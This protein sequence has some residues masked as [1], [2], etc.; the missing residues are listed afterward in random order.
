M[1]IF[2]KKKNIRSQSLSRKESI[3]KQIQSVYFPLA[4]LIIL[5]ITLLVAHKNYTISQAFA[6]Y[7]SNWDYKKVVTITNNSG[8]TLTDYHFL[9]TVNTPGKIIDGKI[10]SDCSDIR[11]VDSDDSTELD[12]W[13][14]TECD[15]ANTEIWIEI[16]S[17]PE[18]DTE[19][20]FYYGNTSA[21]STAL[22]YSGKLFT[23]ADTTCA[24]GYTY[25]PAFLGRFI[26]GGS[27]YGSL[28]G[29]ETHGHADT[30]CTT[31]GFTGSSLNVS[32]GL[33]G[34]AVISS[35]THNLTASV[36]SVSNSPSYRDALVCSTTKFEVETGVI[37]MSEKATLTGWTRFTPFDSRYPRA[38]SVYGTTGGADT[39]THS[40][41]PT[42]TSTSSSGTFA[43]SSVNFGDGADGAVTFSANTNI[44]TT[45]RIS[46]RTCSQGGD[47]VNYSVT[48]L[49]AGS[50]VVTPAPNT[51][52]L[53]AGDEILLINLQGVPSAYVNTGNY[54]VLEI[55]S[56]SGSTVNFVSSK[57]K[58]YGTGAANDLNLGT[59]TTNQRV[60]LQRIPN[61]T[62]VTVNGGVNV[63]PSAWNG[64]RGG[65][66]AFN[67]NGTTVINGTV[68][69]NGFGYRLG[70]AGAPGGKSDG[71][72]SFCSEDG[73][74]D[75]PAYPENRVGYNGNCGGGGGAG[76][77]NTIT[78][79]GGVGTASLGG[80]G[81]AGGAADF[82]WSAAGGGGAGGGYGTAG[83]QG[84]G[85]G[86]NPYYEGYPGGVNSSGNGG[87]AV[88]IAGP[89]TNYGGGGG[90]GGSYGDVALNKLYFG[91]GGGGG[92]SGEYNGNGNNTWGGPGGAGGGIV[93]ISSNS[94]T[95]GGATSSSGTNG[96]CGGSNGGCGGGGAGG[97]VKIVGDT[98]AIG[99]SKVTANGGASSYAAGSGRIALKYSTSWSGSSVPT[100]NVSQTALAGTTIG[101]H[102]HT[103][104]SGANTTATSNEIPYI[105]TV[106]HKSNGQQAFDTSTVVMTDTVPPLGWTEKVNYRNNFAVGSGVYGATGGNSTH[107]SQNVLLSA[108]TPSVNA[109]GALSGG[110][111]VVDNSHSHSCTAYFPPATNL[112]RYI[113]AIFVEKNDNSDDSVSFVAGPE[114]MNIPNAPTEQTPGAISTTEIRWNFTDNSA[115]EDGARVYDASNTLMQTCG[116]SDIT[117]CDE[118]GL[119]TNTPYTRKFTA[120]NAYGQSD[121]S[122]TVTAYTLTN[123]PTIT[124]SAQ[125]EASILLTA[126]NTLNL[127]FGQS[128]VYFDC[129]DASCD[130]GINLWGSSTGDTAT[131]LLSNTGYEFAVK[132]RN[133]DG[134]ETTYSTSVTEYTHA[135]VPTISLGTKAVDSLEL[136]AAN[137]DNITSGSSGLYYD[138]TSSNCDTGLNT[139]TTSLSDISS[140]LLANTK[141]TFAVKARNYDSI[142][143]AFSSTTEGYT[144]AEVP[145]I[146]STGQT[147]S[148]ID[149]SVTG[150][151]NLAQ[152]S[153]GVYFDCTDSGCDTG[154]NNWLQVA[155]DT[156]TG[157]NSNTSYNFVT[158][159]R[160]GDGIETVNSASVLANTLAEA[161]TLIIANTT[162]TT[163]SLT[164]S[165]IQNITLDL[166]GLY[167]DCTLSSCDTGINSWIQV[168][169]DIATGLTP[170]TSYDFIVKARN[171]DAIETNFS[172][173]ANVITYAEQPSVPLVS[174]VSTDALSVILSVGSNPAITE[175][176]VEEESTGKY[177]DPNTGLLVVGEVW[178]TYADF[179]ESAG[180][181]VTGLDSGVNYSF[182][183]KARNADAI[184]TAFSA[185]ASAYTSLVAPVL[186]A[187]TVIDQ[188]SINWNFTDP[189]GF[190]NGVKIYNSSD[191]LIKDC[192]GTDI[193]SCLEDTLSANVGY[194]RK[195]KA[196]NSN[197]E[198]EFSNEISV[199]TLATA[200][201]IS[202]LENSDA[203]NV[204]LQ[205]N[206]EDNATDTEFLIRIN[207]SVFWDHISEAPVSSPVWATSN[208]FGNNSIMD[209][210]L[211]PDTTYTFE[212]KARNQDAVETGY[213]VL[214]SL[215]TKAETPTNPA[216]SDITTESF[217][218]VID[219]GNNPS[220]TEYALYSTIDDKYISPVNS[221]L[222]ETEVWDTYA[223]YNS[224]TGIVIDGLESN[225]AFAINVKARNLQDV[226][227]AE[228]DVT[229]SYTLQSNP[230]ISVD[231][232][233]IKSIKLKFEN[234]NRL[235]VGDAG[236]KVHCESGGCDKSGE[237]YKTSEQ[238]FNNLNVNT[239]Y[240]YRIQAKNA[241]SAL[242]RLTSWAEVYTLAQQPE[243]LDL[244]VIDGQ[245]IKLFVHLFENPSN[246]E[247]C[248]KEKESNSYYNSET[249]ELQKTKV[250]NPL[251]DSLVNNSV[252]V[253][254]LLPGVDYDFA[255]SAINGDGVE[256]TQHQTKA[257]TKFILKLNENTSAR[258]LND[259]VETS[260]DVTTAEGA[261]I[262]AQ[263]VRFYSGNLPVADVSL[264]FSANLD[265]SSIKSDVSEIF[266]SAS[267]D[268]SEIEGFDASFTL[269]AI[270]SET[271]HLRICPD[272]HS[273][274][275]LQ[276][277]C[278]KE[279]I[280][281]GVLP[282]S[283]AD[284]TM[285]LLVDAE[286]IND[287]EFWKVEGV[288]GTAIQ[289]YTPEEVELTQGTEVEVEE[290][291]ITPEEPES[292]FAKVTKVLDQTGEAIVEAAEVATEFIVESEEITAVAAVAS[293]AVVLPTVVT[294]SAV[295]LVELPVLI[296]R[297]VVSI[298]SFFGI[299]KK[300]RKF[301]YV[302]DSLTKAPLSLAVVRFYN[303]A[304]QLVETEVTSSYGQFNSKI[305]EGE[306]K[307][308]VAKSGYKYP[309]KMVIG[310]T[311]G[312]IS[313]IYHGSLEKFNDKDIRELSLPMDSAKLNTKEKA[314]ALG[315]AITG[316]WNFIGFLMFAV[317]LFQS[318]MHLISD[319]TVMN[320]IMV[321][322]Y[323]VLAG[324]IV[325]KLFPNRQNNG[326]IYKGK[327]VQAKVE[328][329][330]K[331]KGEDRVLDHRFTDDDGKYHFVTTPG[332]YTISLPKVKD[333]VIKGGDS[334]TNKG[335][336]PTVFGRRIDIG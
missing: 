103:V 301:G 12:Y 50:A 336:K 146:I 304:G 130:G 315:H 123:V 108:G 272:V 134:F 330:L 322:V 211:N 239:K 170:N 308:S 299:R 126:A 281:T 213:T 292:T 33:G 131:G 161:P 256:T 212:V 45:N 179:S 104:T 257:K 127:G 79:G 89:N 323:A 164:A 285:N 288:T 251:A 139:W 62:N 267:V 205:F 113:T 19:I 74:G 319:V 270:R 207:E 280:V 227:T 185:T 16:P 1:G 168:D 277:G 243:I 320:I 105:E 97:S 160:N 237:W 20:Y 287:I 118:S 326:V 81:G 141:Y 39:H 137:T 26:M 156:A 247:I 297:F 30:S 5:I 307:L 41:T 242:T 37:A 98:V 332:S 86:T 197:T 152:D 83:S 182:K 153:S 18:G 300:G 217:N 269:Y 201:T 11:F 23:Y 46:G 94:I 208:T 51:G 15:T 151:S 233:G 29:S 235:T 32:S 24:S 274:T 178:A 191:A 244:D 275:E 119:S 99:V 169:T 177:V 333:Y 276:N 171:A 58:Y 102:N 264:D 327:D 76:H 188:Y 34:S 28:G 85:Y 220:N 111:T 195:V 192:S 203:G 261:Q 246:T 17:L 42:S 204:Q 84:N 259:K 142:E 56:V 52:C 311:D 159:V 77:K 196:Y 218:V 21:T 314:Y 7:D 219:P 225:E 187:P 278:E 100:A 80:G 189:N 162:D 209:L 282:Q 96:S 101:T 73:G 302:Y 279:I 241:A 253:E 309:S 57:Q 328:V 284:E 145:G 232:V 117:F 2:N 291:T 70:A 296:Q 317:G 44:N 36:N 313:N 193:T 63:Y 318:I 4:V 154:L 93:F 303:K 120:Y 112:P 158:K 222:S 129:I 82:N 124:G 263:V 135:A 165:N 22:T 78:Y 149:L 66:V 40:V 262:G 176:L 132:A 55:S 325:M 293:A 312:P 305:G 234:V 236:V 143:T 294:S 148:S 35:H 8:G 115:N 110:T 250:C 254:G 230:A 61:Y 136:L 167:F 59:A 72:E 181:D 155:T 90:G 249:S 147:S 138:C 335:K 184:E 48:S 109:I 125:T 199:Y 324:L 9:M 166:S 88:Y 329:Q 194:A 67:A 290:E 334:Y 215:T 231:S 271:T 266:N 68:H 260:I 13:L 228:S 173:S 87:G 198:S 128:A 258:L 255:I 206:P 175:F 6:W 226:E 223:G 286:T 14:E 47:A 295:V 140:G 186:T 321:V 92:G 122:G 268:F 172:A 163:V 27:S 31:S 150:T 3:K 121:Y 60:M 91:S 216:V 221:S 157:L 53:S 43:T 10:N 202:L 214:Q 95:I 69:A 54:E 116:A 224:T 240:R 107:A 49:S 289:G 310:K 298:L 144:L 106:F 306:Y 183:V 265:W 133:G 174:P 245:S 331:K 65:V 64:I 114:I 71:G 38:N 283:F 25:E 229:S 75:G 190:E 210:A 180:I 248:I 316:V 273:I 252:T 238:I 200:P